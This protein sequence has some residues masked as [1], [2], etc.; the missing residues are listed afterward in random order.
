MSNKVDI[1]FVLTECTKIYEG[2]IKNGRI[3]VDNKVHVNNGI[4]CCNGTSVK[5]NEN[6]AKYFLQLLVANI[7]VLL[8]SFYEGREHQFPADFY[9]LKNSLEHGSYNIEFTNSGE[10]IVRYNLHQSPKTIKLSELLEICKSNVSNFSNSNV[11]VAVWNNMNTIQNLIIKKSCIGASYLQSLKSDLTNDY[12]MDGTLI[13]SD[14]PDCLEQMEIASSIVLFYSLVQKN[15]ENDLGVN[16][17]WTNKNHS[18]NII[19]ESATK[20]DFCNLVL[21]KIKTRANICTNVLYR[22]SKQIRALS[23]QDQNQ[24]LNYQSN[25]DHIHHIRN[26][27]SH[28]RIKFVG[29]NIIYM[30]DKKPSGDTYE[31]LGYYED[32][33]DIFNDLNIECLYNYL[34]DKYIANLPQYGTPVKAFV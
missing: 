12:I 21:Q 8:P 2:Y 6:N 31:A 28:H 24:W 22:F 15:L 29:G 10:C 33:L 30:Y 9:K 25:F 34:T 13:N 4:Y 14:N 32:F 3:G 27:I 20:F 1:N 11:A 19:N 17:S 18:V 16:V 26:A 23:K 5:I 7:V